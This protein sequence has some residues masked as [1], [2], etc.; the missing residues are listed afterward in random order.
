[1]RPPWPRLALR[2]LVGGGPVG[3]GCGLGWPRQEWPGVAKLLIQLHSVAFRC[4]PY[5]RREAG[6]HP[7]PSLLPSRDPCVTVPG[8]RSSSHPPARYARGG[9][10]HTPGS[11]ASPLCT[12]PF[13][14][15]REPPPMGYARS[16]QGR[17]GLPAFAGTTVRFARTTYANNV[18]IGGAMAQWAVVV[19]VS[20]SS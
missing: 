10:P 5:R 11:G 3:P 16:P 1:M 12:P 20:P 7:H 14:G 2:S 8:G 6:G 4:I 18:A 19:G 15:L 9:H 13:E 17:R